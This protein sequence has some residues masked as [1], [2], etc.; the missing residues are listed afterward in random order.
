[1]TLDRKEVTLDRKAMKRINQVFSSIQRL[2]GLSDDVILTHT[3]SKTNVSSESD[4][5][6]PGTQITK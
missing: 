1:V 2:E 4:F 3:S 6:N 5:F